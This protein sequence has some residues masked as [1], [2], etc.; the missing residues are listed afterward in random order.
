M[1]SPYKVLGLTPYSSEDEAKKM[2]R[3]LCKKYHPDG[4]EG[5][6]DTFRKIQKAW[7]ELSSYGSSAFG[8]KRT[9]ITHST[10]FTF[11]RI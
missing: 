2:Y 9:S 7:E 10:L 3:N 1:D 5:N 6:I 11:R 4:S 8:N